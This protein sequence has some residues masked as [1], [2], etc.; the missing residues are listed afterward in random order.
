MPADSYKRGYDQ[1]FW[2]P[3]QHEPKPAAPSARASF[4]CP[5]LVSDSMAPAEH[6]DGKTYDSKSAYRAVTKAN[7]Y[8]E[9][10]NDPARFRINKKPKPDRA[11]IKEAVSKAMA[12][13]L[14]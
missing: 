12:R 4:P 8:I 10:G 2:K 3:I 1:I 14:T 7:G 11:A 9:V 13:H 6:V 5:M